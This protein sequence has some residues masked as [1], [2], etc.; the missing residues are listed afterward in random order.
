MLF[1]LR[2]ILAVTF[3][4]SLAPLSVVGAPLSQ[5]EDGIERR[6]LPAGHQ[7]GQHMLGAPISNP[8]STAT[9]HDVVGRPDI[10]AKVFHPGVASPGDQRKEAEHLTKVNEFHG[11][12]NTAGHHV[13]FATKHAGPT[14]ENTN[15]WRNAHAAGDNAKKDQLKGQAKELTRAR[16]AH[17]V[18]YH[19]IAHTDTN[20]GNVVYH[21]H[22]GQLTNAHFVDW[23]LARTAGFRSNGAPDA[24]TAAIIHRSG[25]KAVH[26]VTR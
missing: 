15:A 11:S 8:G 24:R 12:E 18:D 20:H 4:T 9:V 21:E 10:V 25:S 14:L 6:G 1:S 5:V 3:L 19:G 17:H 13:I 2:S 22:D 26:G 16:N 23:G 7:V